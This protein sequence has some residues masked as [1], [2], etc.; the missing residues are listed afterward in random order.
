MVLRALCMV[1][2]AGAGAAAGGGAGPFLVSAVPCSDVGPLLGSVLSAHPDAGAGWGAP[3]A[4][5]SEGNQ[6]VLWGDTPRAGVPAELPSCCC[7]CCFLVRTKPLLPVTEPCGGSRS[8]VPFSLSLAME[9]PAGLLCLESS[10]SVPL[11]MVSA[12]EEEA[13]LAASSLSP[14]REEDRHT[15]SVSSR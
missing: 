13:S 2:G 5:P 11:S 4:N 15:P 9:T 12:G 3:N 8:D 10:P 14:S 7:C 6:L 1:T